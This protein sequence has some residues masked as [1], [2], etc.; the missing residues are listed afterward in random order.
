MK[1]CYKADCLDRYVR[2]EYAYD[3]GVTLAEAGFLVAAPETCCFGER[4]ADYSS[5]RSGSPVPDTCHN[6]S[7]YAM[8]LGRTMAGLRVW[9][10]VCAVDYLA[11]RQDADV[12]RLGAM[13]ISGGGMHAFFSTCLDKRIRAD[14][15]QSR[16]AIAKINPSPRVWYVAGFAPRDRHI[17]SHAT[18]RFP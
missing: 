18:G 14:A 7:T 4:T 17:P 2:E 11:T 1:C 16:P 13:G 15:T 9:D 6:A 12:D 5:I 10:G 8:M 3:F